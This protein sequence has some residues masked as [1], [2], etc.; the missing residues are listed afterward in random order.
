M[1]DS[2]PHVTEAAENLHHICE[3]FRPG[4][5]RLADALGISPKTLNQWRAD[6]GIPADKTEIL[7][8]MRMAADIISENGFPP[9]AQYVLRSIREEKT[10]LDIVAASGSATDAA[11]TLVK[12]MQGE[13][14]QRSRLQ[15]RIGLRTPS[16]QEDY[17]SPLYFRQ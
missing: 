17:G 14:E 3:F 11:K 12:V 2:S 7:R 8:D 1:N 4:T 10:L 15:A 16:E 13:L 6:G 9:S 5:S